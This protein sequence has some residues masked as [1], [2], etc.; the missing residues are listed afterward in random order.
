[1]TPAE[2]ALL[3][4]LPFFA[5][6]PDDALRSLPVTVRALDAGQVLFRRGDAGAT[7]YVV[8]SG[9]VK[10]TSAAG[11]RELLLAIIEPGSMF[12]EL[13]LLDGRPRS[14]SAVALSPARLLVLHRRDLLA[15]LA[16][17]PPAALALLGELA[18]RIRRLNHTLEEREALSIPARLARKLLELGDRLPE[19]T[20]RQQELGD[21]VGATRESVNKHLRA[22]AQAGLVATLRGRLTLLDRD[23]LAALARDLAP[24]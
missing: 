21:M 4:R 19:L 8:A 18:A 3:G 12:G 11:L 7:V 22:W 20:L 17:H 5:S 6:L 2:R 16:A 9:R 24:E 15:L 23:G 14:A 1:M 10:I 13:A